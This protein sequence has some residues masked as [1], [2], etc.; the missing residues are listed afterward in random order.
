[1]LSGGV[2]PRES[3]PQFVQQIMTGAPTKP[4]FVKLAQGIIYR[5]GAVDVVWPQFLALAIIVA[6]LL[7]CRAAALPQDYRANALRGSVGH[8][9][10]SVQES[11]IS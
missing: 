5:G 9:P 6:V 4:H 2:T 8:P 10:L 11:H 1:M 7:Q 3:M